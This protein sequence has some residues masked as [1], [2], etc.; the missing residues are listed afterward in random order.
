MKKIDL[1]DGNYHPKIMMYGNRELNHPVIGMHHY[2]IG[3]ENEQNQ[4]EN[5]NK[6]RLNRFFVLLHFDD[7]WMFIF[8]LVYRIL[9]TREEAINK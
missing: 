5:T 1:F 2:Q 7:L 3:H 4:S 6:N 9:K 8:L